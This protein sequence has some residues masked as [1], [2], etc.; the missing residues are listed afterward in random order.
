MADQYQSL[1]ALFA[2]T[3]D[4]S[5]ALS[6][7]YNDLV[8]SAARMLG[9]FY[10]TA[11]SRPP[12]QRDTY[13]PMPR[14]LDEQDN[15][16]AKYPWAFIGQKSGTHLADPGI[17]NPDMTRS[18]DELLFQPQPAPPPPLMGTKDAWINGPGGLWPSYI[19]P[20]EEYR[21]KNNNYRSTYMGWD[22]T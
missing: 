4:T 12:Q 18:G 5:S 21:R 15:W 13:D 3:D 10:S 17:Y 20:V 9:P 16:Y 2:P 22:R 1:A 11:Y 19:N 6:R 14:I 8:N 7:A